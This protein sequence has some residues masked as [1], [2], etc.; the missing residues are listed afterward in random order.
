MP[1]KVKIIFEKR[2]SVSFC[3]LTVLKKIESLCKLK[4]FYFKAKIFI[5]IGD[6]FTGKLLQI[7]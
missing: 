4:R 2:F 7:L 6:L 3:K 1:K 5:T